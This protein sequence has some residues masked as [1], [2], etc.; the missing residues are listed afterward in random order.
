MEE[1]YKRAAEIIHEAELII[2]TAGAGIGVDSGLPDFR[3]NQGFWNA[4]P[5]YEKLGLSFVG[6]A[7]PANFEDDPAFGWGFYGH[8]LNLYRETEPHDG[9]KIIL[10]WCKE[11]K[12]KYFIVTSNV[13]GH[14]KK[15]VITLHKLN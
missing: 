11:K 13:D 9:F 4:Y 14:F 12:V 8:R 15:Q 7:N 6:A 5:M 3:G 10:N 2:I 1:S